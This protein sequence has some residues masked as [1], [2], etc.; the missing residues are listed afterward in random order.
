MDGSTPKKAWWRGWTLRS[1]VVELFIFGFLFVNPIYSVAASYGPISFEFILGTLCLYLERLYQEHVAGE[2]SWKW[3][4]F[5]FALLV[6]FNRKGRQSA[7]VEQAE[8][9]VKFLDVANQALERLFG[10]R[11]WVMDFSKWLPWIALVGCVLAWGLTWGNWLP[12]QPGSGL[13]GKAP[14]VI[15]QSE[16][17]GVRGG[18]VPIAGV[19]TSTVYIYEV[20]KQSKTRGPWFKMPILGI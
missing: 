4:I 17:G 2:V 9:L 6:Y 13:F 18:G 11:K 10:K 8:S 3:G 14:P 7:A 16:V 1:A 15:Y 5:I 20:V 12:D 19:F